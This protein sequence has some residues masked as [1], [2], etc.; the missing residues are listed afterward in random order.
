MDFL[1]DF[2][3]RT[4]RKGFFESECAETNAYS[5]V[6]L[7]TITP[8]AC[9]IQ[10]VRYPSEHCIQSFTQHFPHQWEML[11]V[12]LDALSG[13]PS[14]SRIGSSGIVEKSMHRVTH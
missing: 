11:C 7:S 4:L 1:D 2:I 10:F 9:A 8:P 13:S 12:Y 6:R 5:G 14:A 3:C